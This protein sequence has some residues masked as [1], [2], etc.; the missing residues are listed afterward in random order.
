MI[1]VNISDE[2]KNFS[3]EVVLGCVF[4]EAVVRKGNSDL[5]NE[6]KATAHVQKQ[7][8]GESIGNLYRIKEARSF[9][10]AIGKDPSRYRGSAESLLRRIV[11][12]KELYY[13]N[14]VVDINN[15]VS[16]R[17]RFCVGSYDIEK[18]MFPITFNIGKKDQSYKGIGKSDVN[19]ESLP[20]FTDVDGPFGS[21]TSDSERAMITAATRKLLMMIIS[22]SG[23]DGVELAASE[24]KMY[25]VK[26]ADARDCTYKIVTT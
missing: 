25:L 3:S 5:K 16:V 14:N 12:G 11:V 21:P 4:C 6:M 18:L 9:Y 15:L 1:E 23:E 22:F 7:L 10:K 17:S 19:L 20:I 24:A 26:Y 2:I 8:V 13:V